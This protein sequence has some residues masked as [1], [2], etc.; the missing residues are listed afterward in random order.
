[1]E[2]WHQIGQQ[3]KDTGSWEWIAFI[4]GVLQVVLAWRNIY[5]NFYAG[6]VSVMLYSYVFYAYGLYAESMLN[7]YYLLISIWGLLVWKK[8]EGLAITRCINR[9]WIKAF[10]LFVIAFIFLFLILKYRT[11]S[12]VP[13]WDALVSSL[14]WSGS[15]LLSYRKL[16]NWLVLNLSNMLAIPLLLYKGLPLTAVLTVIYIIVAILG[17]RDWRKL[18][19]RA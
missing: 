5:W 12:M 3:F 13:A 18:M 9:D 1:M 11:N 17:Y 4:F 10:L 6:I 14:A 7:I 16:E 19:N 2:Y 8:K 15:W